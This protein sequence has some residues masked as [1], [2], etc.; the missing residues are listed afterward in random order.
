MTTALIVYLQSSQ[1]C[2]S[3]NVGLK[4]AQRSRVEPH[5]C[6]SSHTFCCHDCVGLWNCERQGTSVLRKERNCNTVDTSH[7]H[8]YQHQYNCT[9]LHNSVSTVHCC[10]TRNM[11]L[12]AH[13]VLWHTDF[14]KIPHYKL[15]W[16]TARFC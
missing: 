9:V 11:N 6:G 10:L 3:A 14:K 1:P 4:T 15:I 5:N 13:R 7:N 2:A 16:H 8:V 12:W